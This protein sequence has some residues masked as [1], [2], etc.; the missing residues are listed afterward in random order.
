MNDGRH[1]RS[2]AVRL[3]SYFLAVLCKNRTYQDLETSEMTKY[4][5]LMVLMLILG[6]AHNYSSTSALLL[7][8]IHGRDKKPRGRRPSSLGGAL[9]NHS[10]ELI[11]FFQSNILLR[12]CNVLALIASSVLLPLPSLA[13]CIS[14]IGSVQ[15]TY[16]TSCC[17]DG[18][19]S[20]NV[21][22]AEDLFSLSP[23]T[24]TDLG[25]KA[26]TEDKPQIT[27]NGKSTNTQTSKQTLSIISKPRE[28][29]LQGLVYFPERAHSDSTVIVQAGQQESQQLDYYNDILVLTAI[30]AT[31]LDRRVLAGA[32]FPVSSA[33]FPLSF[34][35]YE[36]N[37]LI[38]RPGV[39]HVWENIV[40]TGD[41]VVRASICPR[42]SSAFPCQDSERKKYAEGV[43]KLIS[44]LPGLT[45]GEHIR[46]PASL[47]LQ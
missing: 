1:P 42:D 30:S 20:S 41:I 25:L 11:D 43:A 7:K 46:A 12:R 32:K 4:Y 8:S 45:E 47:A 10:T 22:S 17:A 44:N 27:L 38:S 3:H 19:S 5:N 2:G 26:A 18:W 39:R 23:S 29:I 36:E 16:S 33:R 40:D 13:S 31:D 35:M 15:Q 14:S 24:I 28:P 34:Q 9:D 6:S 37:L 21:I